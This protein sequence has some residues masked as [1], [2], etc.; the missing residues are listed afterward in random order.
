[1]IKQMVIIKGI[2]EKGKEKEIKLFGVKANLKIPPKDIFGS[3]FL[4]AKYFRMRSIIKNI[5]IIIAMFFG[6]L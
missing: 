3:K 2:P 4:T 5:A 1:M 6:F